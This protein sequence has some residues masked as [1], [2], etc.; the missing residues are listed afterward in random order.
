MWAGRLPTQRLRWMGG[1]FHGMRVLAVRLAHAIARVHD[2]TQR[3]IARRAAHPAD[4]LVGLVDVDRIAS[5]AR[6][7]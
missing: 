1:K 3:E 5:E 2:E 7:S 6:S 4:A